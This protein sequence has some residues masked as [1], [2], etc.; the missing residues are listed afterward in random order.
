MS[1][2]I[3]RWDLKLEDEVISDAE[4]VV[5]LL[6]RCAEMTGEPEMSGDS[7]S[8]R[9]VSKPSIRLNIKPAIEVLREHA[10]FAPSK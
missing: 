5:T 6:A 3:T 8:D 2:L 1:A 7:E 4:Q 10:E 9:P